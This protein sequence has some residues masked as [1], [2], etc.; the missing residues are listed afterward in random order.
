MSERDAGP[1]TDEFYRN[2]REVSLRSARQIVPFVLRLVEPWSVVDVGCGLGTWLSVFREQGVTDVCGMDGDWVDRT[3]LVIP[4]DRFLAAD[5]CRPLPVD[6][7][8]DL[9]LSLEVAEHLPGECGAAFVG[10]LTR[11]APLVLFSAAIPFQGGAG[12][13]NEQWPEYWVE[14][15]R[16]S[17]YAVIDCIRRAI[18]N[19][20][21]VEWYYAQ[22]TLLFARPDLIERSPTLRKELE[23]TATSQLSLV[24]PRKYLK[25][26]AEMRQLVLTAQDLAA[27]I[28]PGD[29]FILVDDD[30]VR[31]ELA[32]GSRAI[33]FLERDG[34][35]WGP[36]ADDMTAIQELERLRGAGA[37][38]IVFAWPSFWW[39]DYYSGFHEYL[40][41]RFPCL[42]RTDR[43]VVF[44]L[45]RRG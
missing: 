32:V 28:P 45:R 37:A 13:I 5:V 4:A 34:Q 19:N 22:N 42:P 12:H 8:F 31:G 11:L 41:S 16:Q 43:V 30:A 21:E 26:V 2:H 27:V 15:F 25:A 44:D 36:P 23:G 17:G 18:W 33:P 7:R 39:L 38:F 20:A 29:R 6:R 3:K 24:H 10:S 35:Y 1:Y 14:H 9:A 40:R